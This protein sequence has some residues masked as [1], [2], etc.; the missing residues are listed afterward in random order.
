MRFFLPLPI[1]SPFAECTFGKTIREVGSTWFADLGPPFGIMYCIKCECIPV[2]TR[3]NN[4]TTRTFHCTYERTNGNGRNNSHHAPHRVFR[5]IFRLHKVH[6][7][8]IGNYYSLAH[9]ATL[10]GPSGGGAAKVLM[11]VSARSHAARA[12]FC[13]NMRL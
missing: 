11:V 9:V 6:S 10:H 5:L 12:S 8:A 1:Y 4:M 3:H 13:S 2:S 7:L